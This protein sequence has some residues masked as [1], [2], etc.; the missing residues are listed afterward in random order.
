MKGN[1]IKNSVWCEREGEFPR[2]FKTDGQL[3]FDQTEIDGYKVGS[4]SFSK[5]DYER[6]V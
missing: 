2:Y 3:H 1:S 4:L 6:L 5:E